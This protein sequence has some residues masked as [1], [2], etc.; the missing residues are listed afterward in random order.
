MQSQRTPL[1]C[2]RMTSNENIKPPL[3]ILGGKSVARS[4]NHDCISIK[5]GHSTPHSSPAEPLGRLK[6][7][8]SRQ[9]WPSHPRYTHPG[10]IIFVMANTNL[11]ASLDKEVPGRLVNIA[12]SGWTGHGLRYHMESLVHHS[13]ALIPGLSSSWLPWPKQ[14]WS[15]MFFCEISVWSLLIMSLLNAWGE[16]NPSPLSD[17]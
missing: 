15:I 11:S 4:W 17:E 8:P 9:I 6:S 2:F 5:S 13:L 12:T 7:K 10:R 16:L 1:G 3:C 14:L